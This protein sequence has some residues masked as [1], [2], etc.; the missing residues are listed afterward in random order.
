MPQ[1]N[2]IYIWPRADAQTMLLFL[3]FCFGLFLLAIGMELY[4]RRRERRLQVLAEWRAAESISEDRELSGEEWTLLQSVIRHHAP[5]APLK[6]VTNRKAFDDLVDKDLKEPP[7]ESELYER[8]GIVLRDI[9]NRL[10]LSYVPVGQRI[11]T[12]R[13]LYLKQ[14]LWTG[15]DKESSEWFRLIIQAVDEAHFHAVPDG[16]RTPQFTPGQTITFRMWREEDARYEFQA[17]LAR[18]ESIPQTF[19]FRHTR[20]L[21]RMQ[22]REH[23]RLTYVHPVNVG[24]VNAPVDGDMRHVE[25][26]PVVTRLR[27]RVTSL[28]VGGLAV[29]VQQ[30]VPKQILLRL[31]LPLDDGQAVEVN[32]RVIEVVPLAGGQYLLRGAFVGL[33]EN[34]QEAISHFVFRRQQSTMLADAQSQQAAE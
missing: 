16:K 7:Q 8:R 25:Q 24:I 1:S 11:F 5:G 27:G 13:D 10:G 15:A 20:T 22:A 4:R 23:F 33:A 2:P 21:Q 12:T 9:R 18:V 28:S 26:R 30:P 29:L 31:T 3:G 32:S 17:V 34:E 6:A 14:V 19:V